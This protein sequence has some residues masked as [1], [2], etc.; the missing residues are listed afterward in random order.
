[1]SELRCPFRAI[2][3]PASAIVGAMNG[4]AQGHRILGPKINHISFFFLLDANERNSLQM[5]AQL[6]TCQK[7]NVSHQIYFYS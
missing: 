2:W 6:S 7:Q 4:S 1:M 3:Q 5:T